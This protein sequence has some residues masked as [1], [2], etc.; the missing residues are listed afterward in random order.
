MGQLPGGGKKKAEFATAESRRRMS[1][2]DGLASSFRRPDD[3]SDVES[4]RLS[5]SRQTPQAPQ[6]AHSELFDI[7]VELK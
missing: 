1:D 3:W 2:P 5:W 7:F 4:S 6:S